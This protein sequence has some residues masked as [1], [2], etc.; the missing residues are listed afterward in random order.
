MENKKI[1][2]ATRQLM[3][4]SS[5]GYLATNMSENLKKKTSLEIEH[6]I[7]YVTFVMT[8][9]D[10]DGGP[11][12]LLSDLSEHT[13]NIGD[14]NIVSILFYEEQKNTSDF[15]VFKNKNFIKINDNYEDP[16]SRP[17]LTVLG[18]LKKSFQIEHKKRFLKRHPASKL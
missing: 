1:D 3:R 5:R 9:F 6:I 7:P 15:P 16:M 12:V 10:Y 11:L 13:K 14:N 2:F 18:K 8:A 17:R 4:S